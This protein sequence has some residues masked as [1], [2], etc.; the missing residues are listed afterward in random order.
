ME[1][2]TF[3]IGE[4]ITK[5]LKE[6]GRTKTWL[7]EQVHCDSSNFNRILKKQYIDMDLLLR[8]SLA[9]DKNLSFDYFKEINNRLATERAEKEKKE[10]VINNMY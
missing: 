4:I 10:P 3:H 5:E 9:L 2:P 6:Q 1:T 7:A 8:I